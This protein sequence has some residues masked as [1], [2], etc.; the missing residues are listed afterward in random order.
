MTVLI[1]IGLHFLL[2]N[3][4]STGPNTDLSLGW[5]ALHRHGF[6]L[7][8]E[9]FRPGGGGRDGPGFHFGHLGFIEDVAAPNRPNQRIEP[10]TRSAVTFVRSSEAIGSL[11]L[12]T[13]PHSWQCSAEQMST[14][15]S[16]AA[17]SIY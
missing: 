15:K 10:M 7:T 9:S 3:L 2:F 5:L 1:F 11:L 8:T 6:K 14:Q 13:H 4:V 17:V 12:M 16:H